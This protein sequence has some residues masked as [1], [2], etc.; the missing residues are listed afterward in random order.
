[1]VGQKILQGLWRNKI[2]IGVIVI[3]GAAIGFGTY[4]G[5]KHLVY[6]SHIEGVSMEP[7]MHDGDYA[8]GIQ[9]ERLGEIKRGDIIS[10]IP[11][12]SD[13]IYVKR[14]IGLPGETVILAAGKV[15]VDR[16]PQA[17]DEPYL[18]GEWTGATGPYYFEVPEGKYLVLGDNRNESFDSRD[19]DD[20]YVSYENI[21]AKTYFTYWP[22]SHIHYLY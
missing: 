2:R 9:R 3:I 21:M 11:P 22:L 15:Y 14:V 20:P 16:N 17:L 4:Y 7:T 18:D 10:F 6:K 12:V 8:V 1:M 5:M 13:D 19:W